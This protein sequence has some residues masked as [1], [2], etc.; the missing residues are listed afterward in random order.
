[1]KAFASWRP[2]FE[3]LFASFALARIASPQAGPA[4]VARNL[5]TTVGIGPLSPARRATIK[6]GP[7]AAF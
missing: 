4:T 3:A 2:C 1:V 6:G 5:T 7:W